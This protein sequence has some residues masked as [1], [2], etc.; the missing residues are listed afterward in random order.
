MPKAEK[1]ITAKQAAEM[2]GLSAKTVLQ[3]KCDTE[4]LTR[5]PMGKRDV[6]FI[7]S[8]VQAL[9]LTLIAEAR[10]VRA[11]ARALRDNR[12]LQLVPPTPEQ[13]KATVSKY[14]R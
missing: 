2:L 6:R 14:Q 12:V 5:I 7:E 10:Q 1:L 13:I 4:D 9:V 11:Q 3:G 8:E